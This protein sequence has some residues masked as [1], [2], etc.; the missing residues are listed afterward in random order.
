MHKTAKEAEQFFKE[1]VPDSTAEVVVCPPFTLLQV[2]ASLAKQKAGVGAQDV[3][4][5]LEGAYTGEISPRM[6][7]D[8]NCS[9]VLVGHSER[10]RYFHETD[11]MVNRKMLAALSAGLTPVMCVGETL[12]EMQE[13]RTQSVIEKQV[14]QGLAG[15]KITKGSRL[16]LAY[17]PVWAIGTGKADTP[18][19]SNQTIG[20]VREILRD[21]FGDLS[22]ETR[23]LYGG[24]IKPENIRKFMEQPEIDGGLVGGASLD[25]KAF[26][27]IVHCRP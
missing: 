16:V 26:T 20:F 5:E 27:R 15:A 3:F 7:L 8:L 2:V 4:W 11:D 12:E 10:R 21:L 22:D 19:Q 23:I 6:L 9:Y 14:K 24:S 17:E 25:P 18:E 1:F 13:G